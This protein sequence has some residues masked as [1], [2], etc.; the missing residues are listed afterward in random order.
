[1]YSKISIVLHYQ[2]FGNRIQTS[3]Y[4]CQSCDYSF[5]G[6]GEKLE[7]SEAEK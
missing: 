1:M 3:L 6:S 4:E 5:L 7:N 2:S